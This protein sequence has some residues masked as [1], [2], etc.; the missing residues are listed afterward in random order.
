LKNISPSGSTALYDSV[1]TGISLILRLNQAME[2]LEMNEV[3]N[4]V[5]IVLTDGED[6]ASKVKIE[7]ACGL[8]ALIGLTLNQSTIKTWFIGVDVNNNA[9]VVKDLTELSEIGGE[10]ADFV[11][12]SNIKIDEIFEKIRI[13]LGIQK[14][15]TLAGAAT[16]DMAVFEVNEEYQPYLAVKEQK[17]AVLFNLDI[18]GSMAGPKWSK[19]CQSVDK[20]V[21]F[22]GDGDLV[23]GVVFNDKID[24]LTKPSQQRALPAP[25]NYRASP[26]AYQPSN[27]THGYQKPSFSNQASV[28]YKVDQPVKKS[29]EDACVICNIF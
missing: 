4:F 23:A 10:N 18:S 26:T 8:M 3:W 19:V 17:F 24:I 15:V 20:F 13:D 21:R 28:T 25:T 12:I 7:E 1:M 29:K 2:Q 9:Q 14:K 22:L 27:T 11:N 16:N 6:N 5:H